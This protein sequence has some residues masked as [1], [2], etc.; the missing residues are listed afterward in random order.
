VQVESHTGAGVC[1]CHSGWKRPLP[2]V[3]LT[4]IDYCAGNY[5]RRGSRRD[6]SGTE[7]Q[8]D[9]WKGKAQAVLLFTI[10]ISFIWY[11]FEF[12]I[13]KIFKISFFYLFKEL[14]EF[15]QVKRT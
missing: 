5:S 6:V 2:A 15:L 3:R 12:E 13:N 8:A 11:N 9:A 4:C 14:N 10:L 7:G 1:L